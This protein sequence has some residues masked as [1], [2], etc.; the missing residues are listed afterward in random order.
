MRHPCLRL[1][2]LGLACAG[3]LVG[4]SGGPPA[5][6]K[7]TAQLASMVKDPYFSRQWYLAND[8]SLGVKGADVNAEK[9]WAVTLGSPNIIVAILDDGVDLGHEDLK[10]KLVP[11]IDLV[12]GDAKASPNAW[13]A[14][15]TACAGIAAAVSGNAKG[16]MGIGA[17]VKIMPVRIAQTAEGGSEWIVNATILE[18]GIREAV[19]AGAHVLS[20]SWGHHAPSNGVNAAIDGAIAAGRVLVFAAGNSDGAVHWPAN[21][22]GSR[23]VVAVSA[24]DE[25]DQF[26]KPGSTTW[27]SNYGPEITLAAPGIHMYTTDVSG[28]GGFN[29]QGDYHDTFSGTSAATPLVAGVAALI[30][31]QNPRLSPAEVKRRLQQGGKDLGAPGPDDYFGSGRLDACRALQGPNC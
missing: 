3:L 2:V 11:G 13:D 25:W 20:N 10:D 12:D 27:G 8:G 21:R 1:Q 15:G 19:N 26:K 29:R 9:A 4:C 22:A 31:S 5:E 18:Q 23:A 14:H 24:T 28:A 30:L 7:A 17:N 6:K 16:I